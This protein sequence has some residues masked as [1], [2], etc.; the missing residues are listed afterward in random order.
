MSFISR[1]KY[2]YR[3]KQPG[4]NRSVIASKKISIS[5]TLLTEKGSRP[6]YFNGRK[7]I[8]KVVLFCDCIVCNSAEETILRLANVSI[9]PL[10]NFA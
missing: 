1:G 2:C 4:Y 6:K 10:C 8:S 7:C 5:R 3:S 9:I